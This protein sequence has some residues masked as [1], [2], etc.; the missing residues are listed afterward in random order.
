[1]QA[2]LGGERSYFQFCCSRVRP[3]ERAAEAGYVECSTDD[4]HWVPDH[5]WEGG[6]GERERERARERERGREGGR[7]REGEER[8]EGIGREEM[9]GDT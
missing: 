6:E 7:E 9:G 8:A 2:E 3:S 1:M 4:L 5:T